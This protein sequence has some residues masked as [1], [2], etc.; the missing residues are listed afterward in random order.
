MSRSQGKHVVAQLQAD[1]RCNSAEGNKTR[2]AL[3]YP[4][5]FS[6]LF[7]DFPW[8]SAQMCDLL[9]Q[10]TSRAAGCVPHALFSSQY[11][12]LYKLKNNKT[13]SVMA[14]N[15]RIRYNWPPLRSGLPSETS[16]C[17]ASSS[18]SGERA[19]LGF[20]MSTALVTMGWAA[21]LSCYKLQWSGNYISVVCGDV[22]T[23][24]CGG[25]EGEYLY[26]SWLM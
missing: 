22:Y 25:Q 19:G 18:P 21:A 13:N 7:P 3:Y 14:K 4:P 16:L 17:H 26:M 6:G 9:L 5:V 2:S 15:S 24:V 23:F 11:G 20:I 1:I 12:A 10:N 8:P